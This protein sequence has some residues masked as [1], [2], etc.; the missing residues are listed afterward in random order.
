MIALDREAGQAA[1]GLGDVL[2][3]QAADR[4][5]RKHRNEIVREALDAQRGGF[6][7]G[8]R[9]G[10]IDDDFALFGDGGLLGSLILGEHRLRVGG[11]SGVGCESGRGDGRGQCHS[12]AAKQKMGAGHAGISPELPVHQ[13]HDAAA[14]SFEP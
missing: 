7:F 5:S 9:A 3:G 8:D 14:S 13:G 4:I 1:G 10:A 6:G 2:V 11:V 12:G